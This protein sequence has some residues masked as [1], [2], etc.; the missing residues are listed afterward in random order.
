MALS[1]S[2]AVISVILGWFFEYGPS[3]P[4]DFQR[5]QV[6]FLQILHRMI[7]GL[8]LL[9]CF[10]MNGFIKMADCC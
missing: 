2:V 7:N 9:L 10:F 5:A 1:R 3:S 6:I 8:C 4:K